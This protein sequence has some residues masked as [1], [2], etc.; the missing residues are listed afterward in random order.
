MSQLPDKVAK[1]I[2]HEASQAGETVG[3]VFKR[4]A[5]EPDF[6][7]F[8]VSMFLLRD[9]L[10]DLKLEDAEAILDVYLGTADQ[11]AVGH[12]HM[13]GDLSAAGFGKV[14]DRLFAQ[15]PPLPLVGEDVLEQV[16]AECNT[17]VDQVRYW[18]NRDKE[19]FGQA[20]DRVYKVILLGG[21]IGNMYLLPAVRKQVYAHFAD[22]EQALKVMKHMIGRH[23][24]DPSEE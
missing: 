16:I 2:V 20:I 24:H 14:A 9:H 12:W 15:M 4:R 1:S 11:S 5:D 19:K 3:D 23:Y 18:A 13:L 10:P 17:L 21:R 22:D 8:G 6:Q 7:V